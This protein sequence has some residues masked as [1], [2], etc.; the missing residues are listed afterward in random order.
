MYNYRKVT[1]DLYWVGA[2]DHRLALFENIH[3]LY[4]G[5]SYNAYV[6]LDEKT[7]LF[8]TA[9]W[10]V[11][12]QFI[13]NVKAV[14]GGRPLDYLVINHVEPDHAASIEEILLRWPQVR[15]VTSPKAVILLHQFGFPIDA[16]QVEEVQEG[17]SKCFGRHTIAFVSAPMVHWPEA[18]VSF[19]TTS[20]VLFSAD[21]F[22]SFRALDGKLFADEFHFDSEWLDDARRY[23]TNIVGKYGPQVQALLNKASSLVGLDNIKFICPLHGPGWRRD[24]GYLIDKYVHWATYEPEERGVM[25]VYASMYGNTETAAE[26]LSTKLAERGVTNTRLYDVS[27]THVSYLI[28]DLFKYSHLVL[29]SVTYN[30]GIFPPMHSFL[31]DMK[32]LNLQKRTVALVENGSW[33]PRSGALMREELEKLKH[34]D[35]LDDSLTMASSLQEQNL[36][37]MDAL[38]DAI[39]ASVNQ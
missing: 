20:G 39:A 6:L 24:L 37:E 31:M 29:A 25:I 5:V 12:R 11:G 26:V 36:G 19:D 17:D 27:N 14:L 3:P 10:S 7:V 22:G 4:H 9:D 34:M 2:N 16:G 35:I 8:D 1:D 23:Y 38:A 33:A 28:S 18:M 30:L 21:A 32:A 13:D 15:I